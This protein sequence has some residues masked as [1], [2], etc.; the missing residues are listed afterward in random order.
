MNLFL[1]RYLYQVFF[2]CLTVLPVAAQYR[3]D[4]W[5][6][7]QGLPQNS[8]LAIAQTH[9]G[10]L[11]LATYNGLVRFDGVRFTV[12]NKNNTP[13]FKT[14]RFENLF[15]DPTGALWLS[16][17][18]GGLIRYQN[19]V[20]TPVTTKQGLPS[21]TVLNL[22]RTP[23]GM[24]FI[25]TAQGAVWWRN[26]Q[27]V[28]Y[29]HNSK[30]SR[31]YLGPSGTHWSTDENGLRQRSKDGHVTHYN[32]PAEPKLLLIANMLEDRSGA[33]WITPLQRGVFK[34]KHGVL[35][36]YTKR[37]GLS[38]P[39][40]ILKILEDA[41][42][43]LWFATLNSGLI[44][45]SNDAAE[46]VVAYTTADGLSSNGI[47]G[48]YRDH[49]GTLWIGT[50]G[51]GLNRMTRQF[52]S[53]YSEAQGLSGNVAH[54]VLAD[55]AGSVWVG[56][57]NGLS[58]I[59]NGVITNYRN[60]K[61]PGSLPLQGIQSLYEDRSGRLWIGGYDGLCSFKDGV[62]SPALR[63]ADGIGVNVWAIHEDRQGTLWVGTHF[64]LL[65]FPNGKPP[66]AF[67]VKNGLPKDTVRAIHEDRHGTV[68]L[69]T[70]G[71]LV[72][73]EGERFTVFTPKDGLGN[74][75]VWAIHEDGDGVFW[76][77]S[78]DGGLS[79]FK[80]GHFT[81]Y[82]TTQGLYN[83]GVFQILEDERGFL[84]MSCFRGLYRVGKRQLNEYAD[85]KISAVVCTAFGKADGMLSS[86][87][88]G[89]R[90]PSGVKTADGR[91]WFTT[92]RGV[93]VVNTDQIMNNS[94]PPPVLIENATLDRA[95]ANLTAGISTSLSIAPGQANLEIT[96]TAL[97]F[98][99][100]DQIR[101]KYRLFGQDPDW[102]E[103]GTQR[104]A[105]YSYLRPG[106]YTFKVIAANSDGVWN[107]EG[108]QLLITV[109]PAFYQ[110]WWF[111]SL[112]VLTVA[113]IIGL[114]F[115]RRL[116]HANHARRAQ[117]EFAQRLI[118]SQEAE[119]KR[120]ATEL[121]D[122]LGQSLLVIKNR[123]L[124]GSA[125]STEA[126]AQEQF[127]EITETVGDALG[128][129]RAIA[130]NLRPLHLERLGLT[131]TLEEIVADVANA[132]GIE[133]AAAIA[134]L[135]GRFT[136]A[137]EINLYRIVQECLNNIVKHSQAAQASVIL[138]L[139]DT[140]LQITISDDGRGFDPAA[141]PPRRGGMGLTG[142][143]ERVRILGGTYQ[144]H[145]TPGDGTQL[146]I[147]IPLVT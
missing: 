81:N 63:E 86:D 53:G 76:L 116:D 127:T 4:N 46:K 10:Y 137:Q 98:I 39:P 87:C 144:L 117:E 73:V 12:F 85:G 31:V 52:I 88:N 134:P 107:T 104:K 64:G 1:F 106:S 33:L 68:W 96:Y 82:T 56:T 18:N 89:G 47:R 5:T 97:S 138:T 13:A 145:S 16:I 108:A 135:D 72:K 49:E 125:T 30:E 101:F 19:G 35:T 55:R 45:F 102:V 121:H 143:A 93:A 103:A 140:E 8:V 21:D 54:A 146:R 24:L 110:T 133:I 42:G 44:H 20:F 70:E 90:Q 7:E 58:R 79:R 139:R 94:L 2:L 41:D 147:S 59:T 123:A 32:L 141:I 11:W 3:F 126:A 14:S 25:S 142:L 77:G 48:L 26:N 118:D 67:T 6:T 74:E 109:L 119:R 36:D 61:I 9:D 124:L 28:A 71:G 37:L 69:G 62:F 78:F 136:Q 114:I 80:D 128:E 40:S 38:N 92:L 22:Q 99:K 84:W 111:R 129:V 15:E 23:D 66:R 43:S 57:H 17:E 60:A 130:Y 95:S 112:M 91:L 27:S 100:S 115:K 34:V 105:T 83:N 122:G 132:S 65:K 51:G 131:T 113:G 120:I 50:D 29:E 75:R